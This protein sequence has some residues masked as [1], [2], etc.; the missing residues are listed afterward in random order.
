MGAKALKPLV[1]AQ[2]FPASAAA[3]LRARLRK[4]LLTVASE[5]PPLSGPPAEEV[6]EGGNPEE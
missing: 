4:L 1:G 2:N 5:I 3:F 6:A